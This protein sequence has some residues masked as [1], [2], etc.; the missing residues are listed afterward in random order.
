MAAAVW[1]ACAFV[2]QYAGADDSHQ[3]PAACLSDTG[4]ACVAVVFFVGGKVE[5]NICLSKPAST[6]KGALGWAIGAGSN[7]VLLHVHVLMCI[8]CCR[9]ANVV[10]MHLGNTKT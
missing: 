3:P 1:Q 4:W 9:L 6:P 8:G 5:V 7:S 2:W 10:A